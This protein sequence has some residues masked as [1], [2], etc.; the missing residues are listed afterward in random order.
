MNNSDLT[1][2]LP[3]SRTDTHRAEELVALGYPALSPVLPHL[4]QWLET[5]GSPVELILRP[6]FAELGA[7]A[8]DLACKALEASGKPA[9]KHCLLRHVLP[10]WPREVLLTLPVEQFLQEY[11][12]HGL[13]VWALRLM[14]DKALPSNDGAEGLERWQAHKIARLK[15]QL[16]VL[17][18]GI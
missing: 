13:D 15:E 7:P 2:R 4:F 3:R 1:S 8:R 12:F 16:D 10:S 17:M 14:I 6:F 11:D 18:D 5:S 9:L